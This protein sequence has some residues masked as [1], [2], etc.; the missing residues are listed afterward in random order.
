MTQ[1]YNPEPLLRECGT[2]FERWTD[3][4]LRDAAESGKLVIDLGV[5]ELDVVVEDKVEDPRTKLLTAFDIPLA[6]RRV[7][8]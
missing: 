2:P 6:W 7:E 8:Q 1:Q 3:Q 5:G 4:E